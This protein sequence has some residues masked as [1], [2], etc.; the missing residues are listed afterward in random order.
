MDGGNGD[1]VP[2]SK[3]VE[4]DLTELQRLHS[5]AMRPRIR[6]ALKQLIK[7]VQAETA[8]LQVMECSIVVDKQ[9]GTHLG[10][11]LNGEEDGTLMVVKI[12]EG[13]LIHQWNEENPNTVVQP[14]DYIV[15]VNDARGSALAL[16]EACRQDGELI[17]K[18]ERRMAMPKSPSA[19][20][21]AA[22][23]VDYIVELEKESGQSLGIVIKIDDS[24]SLIVSEIAREGLIAAWNRSRNAPRVVEVGDCIANV[25]GVAGD[26]ALMKAEFFK[27]G[28]QR[29]GM[30]GGD[31]AMTRIIVNK[32]DG[33]SLGVSTKV[34][35]EGG[36]LVTNVA[37]DGLVST[38]NGA[39]PGAKVLPGHR[40]IEVNGVR[41]DASLIKQECAKSGLLRMKLQ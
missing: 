41:G 7:E 40:I 23:K 8:V 14:G 15:E 16:E 34:V 37:E 4:A 20:R 39:H 11:T 17:I 35:Q 2:Q 31:K 21:G 18:L 27:T 38:W 26:A 5:L 10:V 3:D 33:Q 25:N 13:G 24:G 12:L 30:R 36:L 6:Q 29:L 19:R 32:A 1:A 9:P 22:S 28:L